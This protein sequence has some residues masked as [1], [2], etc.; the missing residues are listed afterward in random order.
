ME[1]YKVKVAKLS[2]SN[3]RDVKKKALSVYREIKRQT[4]RRPYIDQPTL[5]ETKFFLTCFGL[6]YSKRRISG[7]KPEE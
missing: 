1:I 6:I 2:G 4:K 5:R 3:Y 7:T